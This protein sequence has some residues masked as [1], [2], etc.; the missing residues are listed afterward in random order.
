MSISLQ[1][2]AS[3][4]MS[5]NNIESTYCPE[6]SSVDAGVGDILTLLQLGILFQ[7]ESFDS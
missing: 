4:Y 3:I 2:L 1:D 6:A 5:S 7:F